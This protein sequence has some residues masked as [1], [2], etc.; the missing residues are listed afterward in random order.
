MI[1]EI[2]GTEITPLPLDSRTGLLFL[3]LLTEWFIP[4]PF[5]VRLNKLVPGI[6]A[7]GRRV[8]RPGSS[9]AQQKLAGVILPLVIMTPVFAFIIAFRE[10][11]DGVELAQ[12]LTEF[13]LLL[14][15]LESRP[16]RAMAKAV[17]RNINS[18]RKNAAR[19]ILGRFTL[20]VTA[21]LSPMGMYKAAAE[22]AA[23]RL[24]NSFYVPAFAYLLLGIYGALA[25]KL[26]IIMSMA[27]N[28][29]LPVN[30]YFGRCCY[31]VEQFCFIL[32]AIW[33]IPFIIMLPGGAP[34]DPRALA[35]AIQSWPSK[36]TAMALALL[37][38]KE[39]IRLGGPR[40]YLLTLYRFPEIGGTE[41]PTEKS[42]RDMI[43]DTGKAIWF[44]LLVLILSGIGYDYYSFYH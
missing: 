21:K 13:F 36:T 41:N 12:S 5:F 32:P 27:F 42:V 26:I 11:L 9:A 29:K 4:F 33:L 19:E 14:L 8:N 1:T 3:A 35:A 40:Y 20:R 15:V 43:S 22:S 38:S 24:I 2:L 23:L 18:D 10:I 28:L 39:N 17:A 16:E 44:A 6:A 34:A 30:Q 37:A 31:F 25:V 7:L